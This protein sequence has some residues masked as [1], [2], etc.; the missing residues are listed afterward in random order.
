MEYW[1]ILFEVYRSMGGKRS[2]VEWKNL[3]FFVG[4]LLISAARIS[5]GLTNPSDGK[6]N[7]AALYFFP[8]R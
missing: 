1:K 3:K 8:F 4:F 7:L 2:G 6:A 5:F